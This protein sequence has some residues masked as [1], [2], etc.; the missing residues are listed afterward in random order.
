LL[1]AQPNPALPLPAP[2]RAAR[3][4]NL[5]ETLATAAFGG[6]TLGLL[7]VPAGWLSGAMLTVAAAALAG[8]PMLMPLRLA[9]AIYIFIGVSLGG[10]A[11]PQTLHGITAYPLSIV[12][13]VVAM[14]AIAFGGSAYLRLVHGWD[15]LSAFLASAPG[16]LSQVMVTAAELGAE[17]RGIAIVQ[18]VRVV[19]LAI[20]LPAGLVLFG[21][22]GAVRRLGGAL[23]L[24]SLDE[25]AILT[26]TSVIV[27]MLAHR[28]RFPGGLLFGSML[29]SALL[30]G[31]G[32]IHAVVPWW[33]ANTAMVALGAVTGSRFANTTMDT[34][35]KFVV[36]AF[37]TLT[38]SVL[39]GA[40]VALMLV[41]VS[42]LRVADV[43][44]A[45]A[46]GAVDAMMLLALALNVD[47]VY[48]GAHHLARI[49][50]V[51]MMTPLVAH[52][53]AKRATLRAPAQAM[54][55][56]SFQD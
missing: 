25:L 35:L 17:M 32:L 40:T 45:F 23:T 2:T 53:V 7:G 33:A 31:S 16:G 47:P 18:S 34:L 44:I 1:A 38:V 26:A 42:P 51:S 43:M 8:R 19:V 14:F 41:A 13:L 55:P 48:V 54:P 52:R 11:T 20:A 6:C 50:C 28:A 49:F 10:V 15:R 24:A 22:A 3:L 12:M 39:I 37:G 9:Q 5:A 29:A 30:H 36:A 46:P 4:G 21:Q 27:A 56:P